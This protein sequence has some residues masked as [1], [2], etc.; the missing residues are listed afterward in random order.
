MRPVHYES[1]HNGAGEQEALGRVQIK[2][3]IIQNLN[4]CGF[5]YQAGDD[6]DEQ[7]VDD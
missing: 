4:T 2:D 6:I 7:E 3:S 5:L 1:N